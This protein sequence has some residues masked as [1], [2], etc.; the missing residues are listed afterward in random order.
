MGF[1]GYVAYTGYCEDTRAIYQ[2]GGTPRWGRGGSRSRGLPPSLY[3]SLGGGGGVRSRGVAGRW[4]TALGEEE[5]CGR[6]VKQEGR[7]PRCGEEERCGRAVY[8]LPGRP[9]SH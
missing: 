3:T 2:E 4:Y 9:R 5:R 1:N 7:T 6:A 8:H